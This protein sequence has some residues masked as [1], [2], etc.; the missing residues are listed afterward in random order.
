ML[1]QEYHNEELSQGK[2]VLLS[3]GPRECRLDNDADCEGA[4]KGET[5]LDFTRGT[6]EANCVIFPVAR[7]RRGLMVL[8][9]AQSTHR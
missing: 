1:I 5:A 7:G 9:R 3:D 2:G 6:A 8:S 4:Q